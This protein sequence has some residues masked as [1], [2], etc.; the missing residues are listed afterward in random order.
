LSRTEDTYVPKYQR[1]PVTVPRSS[2][3]IGNINPGE[4]GYLIDTT[5]N[6]RFWPVTVGVMDLDA[7][8]RDRDQLLAE[9]V[10]C[11]QRGDPWW[12][13]N[14]EQQALLGEEQAAREEHDEWE[15]VIGR[16][17][18]DHPELDQVGTAELAVRAIGMQAKEITRDVQRRI[19]ISMKRLGFSKHRLR[20]EGQRQWVF[21]R[22]G[23]QG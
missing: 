16:Y 4:N 2:V 13:E 11:Y 3:L 9:A 15:V 10:H 1:Q 21:R 18:L 23:A 14:G 22:P 6:R 17:L 8:R 7:F 20:L 12:V 19:G 5:G